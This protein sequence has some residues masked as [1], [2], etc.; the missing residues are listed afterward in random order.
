MSGKPRLNAEQ[1]ADVVR[2]YQEGSDP[3]LI[4]IKYG[5]DRNAIDRILILAGIAIR[6]KAGGLPPV[7]TEMQRAIA[8]RYEEVGDTMQMVK[9]FGVCKRTIRN[10]CE[11][12]GV[13]LF[14]RG[15]RRNHKIY[16]RKSHPLK[17]RDIRIAD[18]YAEGV[19]LQ[20][21]AEK[22]SVHLATVYY[23]LQ[24]QKL[25]RPEGSDWKG[26]RHS[27]KPRTEYVAV[28]K[29]PS[30]LR[31]DA[32]DV[33]DE[34]AAYWVGYLM[35]DGCISKDVTRPNHRLMM[36]LAL[37]DIVALERLKEWLG[38]ETKITTEKAVDD[39]R[40]V[41]RY[42]AVIQITS[43]RLCQ[44]LMTF[45]VV[46]N[47]TEH[48]KASPEISGNRD[49]WRGMVDGDGCVYPSERSRV[50]LAGT[51][52]ITEQFMDYCKSLTADEAT[53]RY[54]LSWCG[55]AGC[56]VADYS[57]AAARII[58]RHLYARP[59]WALPRKA[60]IATTYGDQEA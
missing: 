41:N 4:K 45:G 8:K 20:I 47:K 50:Y 18:M 26:E 16:V 17:P 31:V 42:Y 15:A 46:P 11:R 56:W 23:T 21:I 5:M 33:L 28:V 2:M 60:L 54:H 3:D 30:T 44:R 19:D 52:A 59:V 1:R 53:H 39:R 25:F 12:L 58:V 40:F 22:E 7:P 57:G 43:E 35:A 27:P 48:A 36:R 14:P 34:E 49:F 9:D 55:K 51:K 24:K 37:H 6:K 29:P 13:K 10:I 38:S 32:F